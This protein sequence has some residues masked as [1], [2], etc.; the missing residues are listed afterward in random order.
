MSSLPTLKEQ[1]ALAKLEEAVR[2]RLVLE[3]KNKAAAKNILLQ[4]QLL[5]ANK[6][7]N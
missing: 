6:P 4:M 5:L 1:L 3:A 2:V 7:K